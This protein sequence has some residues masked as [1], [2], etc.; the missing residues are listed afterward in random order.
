MTG[1]VEPTAQE[2]NP[3]ASA[4]PA[5]EDRF[6][7]MASSAIERRAATAIALS[8]IGDLEPAGAPGFGEPSDQPLLGLL[9][10][11]LL[12]DLPGRATDARDQLISR[13]QALLAA[14][15]RAA[16]S[17]NACTQ[18]VEASVDAFLAICRHPTI[19]PLVASGRW[20]HEVPFSIRMG[21]DIVRGVIDSVV[22]HRAGVTIVEFKTGRERPE[23]QHQLD[24]YRDAAALLFP[25]RT[26]EAVLVY[27]GPRFG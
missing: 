15:E 10:H 5:M 12:E 19:A 6:G 26:I 18:I 24:I 23:H 20:L 22:D 13:A 16:L 2:R 14:D 8:A 9:V 7:P 3:A 25:T 21:A 17:E 1:L 11:R 4:A 27:A